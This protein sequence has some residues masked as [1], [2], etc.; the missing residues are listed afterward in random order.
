MYKS[1]L[2]TLLASLRQHFFTH[3]SR[4][5]GFSLCLAAFL[6][7][8]LY[9]WH[10]LH[11]DSSLPDAHRIYRIT[12]TIDAGEYVER[13]ASVPYPVMPQLLQ[14]FPDIVESGA[15][16][17][18]MQ[19]DI[20][21]FKTDDNRLFNETK[22]FFADSNIFEFFDL[23]LL[24]GDVGT[25]LAKPFTMILS[26]GMAEK[27]FGQ[28]NPVG[29][30]L[31]IGGFDQLEVTITGV[32]EQRKPSHFSSNAIISMKSVKKLNPWIQ[33][34]WVW[35]PCWTYLKLKPGVASERLETEFP[36]FVQ[37]HYIA[38]LKDMVSHQLQAVQ[39]IHL[40]S[41]LEFELSANS[42]K[43]Q[44]FILSTGAFFLLLVGGVNFINLS[45]ITF[46]ARTKEFAVRKTL[47][48]GAK[49]IAVQILL[50]TLVMVVLSFL[51]A[52]LLIAVSVQPFLSMLGIEV[53]LPEFFNLTTFG[54]LVVCLLLAATLS[55]LYPAW[56]FS[57]IRVQRILK[58]EGMRA[59]GRRAGLFRNTLVVLQLSVST[60][61]IVFSI[62]ASGQLKFMFNKE[63]GFE[64]QNVLLFKIIGTQ[65]PQRLDAVKQ[66]L[67]A[68]TA[69][70]GVTVMN[71]ILG[72]NNNNH[73]F[74]H[75]G[76]NP[77]EFRYFPALQVD[78]DFV[79]TFGI[80]LLAGRDFDKT[81]AGEDS[82]AV[83]V[84]KAMAN[85]LAGPDP[86]DCLGKRLH[87]IDGREQVVGVLR[88]FHYK[89]LR[90]TI[91]PMVLDVA[92]KPNPFHYYSKIMAVRLKEVN[93]EVLQHLEDVWKRFV[94]N[95]PFEYRF[96]DDAIHQT[97]GEERRLV[98]V[99]SVFTT[100]SVLVAFLGLFSLSK[101]MAYFKAKEIA[102]RKVFGAGQ[103]AALRI[104][105]KEPFVLLLI[106]FTLAIPMG[107][108]AVGHWLQS[109]A[110]RISFPYSVF[111]VTVGVVALLS[112]GT[113]LVVSIRAFRKKAVAV[114]QYE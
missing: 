113:A 56:R 3:F 69:I 91:E 73:E 98:K 76:M 15:R 104:A 86:L 79:S 55:G 33:Q 30:S 64:T 47:G 21:S 96:L 81:R 109:F 23:P 62:A 70:Q 43:T 87:S 67:M 10:E 97:Y 6:L 36:A 72:V 93:P 60:L 100:L 65:I 24:E 14:D 26:K 107:A 66:E 19:V 50:E 82:S 9:T 75:A 28:E 35:N 59:P 89:S 112:L 58:E 5:L 71:E 11:Y 51:L 31:F 13:S 102:I 40:E 27:Y 68:H 111:I 25:A 20:K 4:I 22:V 84:N 53:Y 54:C 103:L 41:D 108:W 12:E 57:K 42:S 88:N 83:L 95:N 18:D 7:V 110:Y 45:T 78:E 94:D 46:L 16:L 85:F 52:L 74:N 29:R 32:Y 38:R 105:L 1:Y 17:F 90:S 8:A 61:L 80:E 39:R 63:R 34:N 114:L 106:A 44:L 101:F 48:A 49:E 77:G 92:N 99:L 2:R 37:R